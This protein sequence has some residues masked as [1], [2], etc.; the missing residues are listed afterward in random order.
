MSVETPTNTAEIIIT[1]IP[2]IAVFLG[3]YFAAIIPP[4]I[5]EIPI[6]S[7]RVAEISP[8]SD[9]SSLNSAAIR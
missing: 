4:G 6:P 8:K 2:I 5:C 7:T 9:T 3:P 1:S